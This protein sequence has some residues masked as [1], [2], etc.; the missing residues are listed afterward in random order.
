MLTIEEKQ[1]VLK[2]ALSCNICAGYL[3]ICTYQ[4]LR[5][6][7]LSYNKNGDAITSTGE[8]WEDIEIRHCTKHAEKVKSY[9]DQHR[10]HLKSHGMYNKVLDGYCGNNF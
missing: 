7:G 6:P 1:A 2:K 10:E 8:L 5:C 9:I 3:A 4:P